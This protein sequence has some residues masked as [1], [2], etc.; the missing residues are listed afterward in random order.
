ME[1]QGA[2][3][4]VKDL[5]TGYDFP[6]HAAVYRVLSDTATVFLNPR[7]GH[8]PNYHPVSSLSSSQSSSVGS[9]SHGSSDRSGSLWNKKRLKPNVMQRISSSK[10]A[11]S[12]YF[13]EQS[14]HETRRFVQEIIARKDAKQLINGTVSA[15]D[16]DRAERLAAT[17]QMP[18]FDM[19]MS[20]TVTLTLS[21]D[22]DNDENDKE[23]D[24][25]S[26]TTDTEQS[27]PLPPGPQHKKARIE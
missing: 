5:R 12:K 27:D 17:V 16:L 14:R 7:V 8:D 2:T 25:G 19:S 21:V 24:N 4:F 22:N 3:G 20:G 15:V 9:Q 26:S 11:G 6:F 18:V 13:I 1:I 23:I 10:S